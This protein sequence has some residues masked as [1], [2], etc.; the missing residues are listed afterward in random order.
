V[1]GSPQIS[2][3]LTVILVSLSVRVGL[4]FQTLLMVLSKLMYK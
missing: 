4:K 3:L 1:L 2:H